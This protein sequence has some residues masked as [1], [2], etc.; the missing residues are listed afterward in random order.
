[1]VLS[2]HSIGC[3]SLGNG[4]HAWL[5]V[6]RSAAQYCGTIPDASASRH[7]LFIR[8]NILARDGICLAAHLPGDITR[9]S[10]LLHL[11]TH[12]LAVSWL[13]PVG[14]F[15]AVMRTELMSL[16]PN[17]A[18][19][20]LSPGLAISSIWLSRLIAIY[21]A[22]LQ[23]AHLPMPTTRESSSPGIRTGSTTSRKRFQHTTAVGTIACESALI[24]GTYDKH[25]DLC[26][27]IR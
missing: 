24:S 4:T 8:N 20:H 7:K 16:F 26:I 1:M 6:F 18:N 25:L 14:P 15:G 13:R 12:H 17:S 3:P 27:F 22:D 19:Y 2:T 5:H 21:Y 23:A 11:S 10:E 9:C